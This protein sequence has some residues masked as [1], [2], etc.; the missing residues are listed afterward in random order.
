MR[1]LLYRRG[2]D[3]DSGAGQ[4]IRMQARGLRAAGVRVR[5]A[6]EH[7]G[8][9]FFL[10]TGLPVWYASRD[11]VAR[12]R[13]ADELLVDH[14]MRIP[15]ADLVFVHNLATE[16][17][18][19][20]R[21]GDLAE[22]SAEE[23][24]FFRELR[25]EAPLVANSELVKAAL[26]R[27]FA[28]SPERIVVHYPGFRSERF[29]PARA[30]ALR[31]RGRQSLRLP[32][33]APLFGFVTSGDFEK[34]GLASFL[35]AAER[36]GAALPEACFLVV[37]S[38]RLPEWAATHA[39]VA[40][41]RVLYRPKGSTPDVWMASLD[42]FVYAARFE[43]FGMVILEALALGVPVVTS[44]R[45]GAAECLP[46]SYAPWVLE[47]PDPERLA[48]VA[49]E[50]WARPETRAALTAAGVARARELDGAR[51][52]SATVATILAQNRRLR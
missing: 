12:R 25:A 17:R 50:L 9:E 13:V 7:G 30:A 45:V 16:A 10:R 48:A 28:V 23:A 37:G 19:H 44:R 15:S 46:A 33:A 51:Y 5:L 21:R 39:S 47:A 40:G 2:L 3:L 31:R 24:A 6:C 35:D 52:A 1:V 32:Q 49:L 42:L 14:S 29:D 22:R 43:E 34:R 18:I 41:G 27:H 8:L 20:L 26:I 38:K 4:L 11:K 36:I